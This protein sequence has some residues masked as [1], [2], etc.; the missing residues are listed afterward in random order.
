MESNQNNNKKRPKIA[1]SL[2]V[3]NAP[4]YNEKR[5]ALSHDWAH[6]FEKIN[7]YPIFVPNQMSDIE[8]FLE[9]MKVDG[10]ILS[11]GDNVGED[12]ERD[13]VEKS[14]IKFAI[15]T[16]V[17]LFG[18]CRGMQAINKFFEGEINKSE[19]SNHVGKPHEVEIS[20]PVS[21][22][23]QNKMIQV[24]SF[25]NNIIQKDMLGLGL[26]PFAICQEDQTIE[27]F[28]HDTHQISG[29]MWHPE[30]EQNEN[31]I[32]I[33]KNFLKQLN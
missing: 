1:I 33:V 10:I 5:D 28:Y 2:R 8:N 12:L 3:V 26:K 19:T 32:L 29:V 27:G 4:N 25:H 17:P 23:I 15:T 22:I 16:K 20:H 7:A 14:M 9:E 31:N 13:N 18:V 21:E 30:R 11:G 6:F 24:N